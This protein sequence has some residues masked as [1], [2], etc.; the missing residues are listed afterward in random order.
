M[1]ESAGCA[2]GVFPITVKW[3]DTVLTTAQTGSATT[4]GD[5][6]RCCV[7]CGLEVTCGC[8]VVT[9]CGDCCG[10]SC[11]CQNGVIKHDE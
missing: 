1:D 7:V 5:T 8:H 4:S 2:E 3:I 10:A 9:P 6:D 11:A